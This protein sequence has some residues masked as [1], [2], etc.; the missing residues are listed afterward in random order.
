MKKVTDLIK[1][2][3][4]I[5]SYFKQK[6]WN[7][8]WSEGNTEMEYYTK[9]DE[10]KFDSFLFKVSKIVEAAYGSVSSEYK[11]LT[12]MSKHNFYAV[13][14]EPEVYYSAKVLALLNFLNMLLEEISERELVS[15]ADISKVEN[16]SKKETNKVFI[17]HGRNM[18]WLDE[19]ENHILSIGYNPVVLYKDLQPGHTI[20]EKLE[21]HSDAFAAV[22]LLTPDDEGKLISDEKAKTRAR[23]NVVFEYGY[24]SGVI[25]R[26]NVVLVDF[27][28]EEKPSDVSGVVYSDFTHDNIDKAKNEISSALIKIKNRVN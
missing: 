13:N 18:K 3:E 24:F 19:I 9:D 4:E 10:G 5:R 28:V 8:S 20:I 6:S 15:P 1:E 12:R 16:K 17:V 2:S 14:N 26:K 23:Q 25:G 11:E 21:M 27:G 22:I 7:T